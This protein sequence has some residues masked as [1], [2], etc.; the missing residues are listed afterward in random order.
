LKT[1]IRW[2]LGDGI[3]RALLKVFLRKGFSNLLRLS[4]PLYYDEKYELLTS[5]L[6]LFQPSVYE[7]DTR[8]PIAK[9]VSTLVIQNQGI[10][11]P[12]GFE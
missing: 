9:L 1:K 5:R 8:P 2:Q 7:T 12:F 3:D 4:F 11:M 10:N 6:G